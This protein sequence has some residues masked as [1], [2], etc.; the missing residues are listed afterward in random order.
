VADCDVAAAEVVKLGGSVL[1]AP[2]DVPVVG[3]MAAVADPQGAGFMVW[4]PATDPGPDPD[5]I[6]IGG[7]CWHE[8]ATTDIA[9]A[10]RFYGAMFGWT[11]MDT[12]DMG[13]M[14]TYQFF[15]RDGAMIGGMYPKPEEVPVCNWLPYAMV[16]SADTA[17]EQV[18][19]TGGTI[20]QPP[21]DVPGG[22]ITMLMD[23]QG[24]VFAVHSAAG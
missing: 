13:E 9:D 8:L 19:D 23:P 4:T 14:G 15:G 2:W 18:L 11:A 12:M 22:R 21:T 10:L 5:P 3:R 20:L 24:A 1:R 6:P 7:F 16:A 17:A